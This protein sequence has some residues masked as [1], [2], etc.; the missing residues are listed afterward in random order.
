MHRGQHRVAHINFFSL[1][2][3]LI[4]G[5]CR[6]A[7]P[8]SDRGFQYGDGL[9]E[10]IAIQRGRALFLERH[11]Q[12]LAHGCQQLRLP[13]PDNALLRAEITQLIQAH[14]T[15]SAVLKIIIT[16]G[17]GGR[18]YRQ[19][20]S[21]IPTR[22]LS[23]HP[24]P[25]YPCSYSQEGIRV[26]LCQTRLGLNPQ[27]AGIKHLN[28]LE[29]VLARAEWDSPDIQEGIVLDSHGNVIEA[30]MSNVFY[31]NQG[32]LYTAKLSQSG[33]AG[34]IRALILER[35][36]ALH[37][38][39]HVH[40]FGVD[41]LFN[42]D[43]VFVCN[44]IIGLWRVRQFEHKQFNICADALSLRLQVDLQGYTLKSHA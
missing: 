44:S 25:D 27:L 28:R 8:S 11:L 26:K 43:E 34:I 6:D 38:P 24:F 14:N 40:S 17:S 4:N 13:L 32:S 29:Q 1:L 21:I 31:V 16:R 35:A 33:V 19:P 39:C 37:I 7:I 5:E 22:L 3:I 42:A 12:R 41:A 2:M 9:F 20:A 15:Q 10:T 23:L 18:G 36:A 30:T